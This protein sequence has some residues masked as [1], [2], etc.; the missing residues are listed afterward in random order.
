MQVENGKTPGELI[1]QNP[2][3]SRPT[4]NINHARVF[5]LISRILP[6]PFQCWCLIHLSLS[7]GCGPS[8][9]QVTSWPLELPW[10]KDVTPCGIMGFAVCQHL[11]VAV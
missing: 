8:R 1:I 11:S 10:K 4:S 3:T 9:E 2:E 6:L 5:I 7:G